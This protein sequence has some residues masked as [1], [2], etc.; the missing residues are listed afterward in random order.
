MGGWSAFVSSMA[1]GRACR[2]YVC[3]PPFHFPTAKQ[4]L[5]SSVPGILQQPLSCGLDLT[6]GFH[7]SGSQGSRKPLEPRRP[8]RDGPH[9]PWVPGSELGRSP[10]CRSCP[11][12]CPGHLVRCGGRLLGPAVFFMTLG[13]IAQALQFLSQLPLF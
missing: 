4:Q 11:L 13:D 9:G 5:P 12:P 2:L 8:P 1:P 3:N 10:S 6:P 7:G